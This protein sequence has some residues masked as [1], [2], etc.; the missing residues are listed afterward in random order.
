MI[1]K[2]QPTKI[3]KEMQLLARRAQ[4]L[5]IPSFVF[6]WRSNDKVNFHMQQMTNSAA[7]NI[8]IAGIQHVVSQELKGHPEYSEEYRDIFIRFLA[9]FQ[10]LVKDVNKKVEGFVVKKL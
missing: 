5:G 10:A 3:E 2:K 4:D 7:L 1:N 6:G 8:M 9:E